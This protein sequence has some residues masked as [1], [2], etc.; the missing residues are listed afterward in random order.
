MY[1]CVCDGVNGGCCQLHSGVPLAFGKDQ[2]AL[3]HVC[4]CAC[5]YVQQPLTQ[6]SRCRYEISMCVFLVLS[7]TCNLIRVKS[8]P[9][10]SLLIPKLISLLAIL[11]SSLHL[12]NYTSSSSL[13]PRDSFHFTPSSFLFIFFIESQMNSIK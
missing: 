7:L 9:A 5:F 12:S 10:S 2:H 8:Y 11:S 4:V 6:V 3:L 1:M 13:F